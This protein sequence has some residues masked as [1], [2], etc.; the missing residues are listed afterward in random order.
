MVSSRYEP[1]HG[2]QTRKSTFYRMPDKG[3]CEVMLMLLHFRRFC[4]LGK[5]M[6]RYDLTGK[7]LSSL[8]QTE[9]CNNS[10]TSVNQ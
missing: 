5:S 8:F 3:T 7:I 9:R 6:T 2:R 4:H 1:V 10:K